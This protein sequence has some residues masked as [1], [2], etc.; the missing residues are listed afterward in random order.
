MSEGRTYRPVVLSKQNI[1]SGSGN[2]VAYDKRSLPIQNA[3]HRRPM[4]PM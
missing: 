1:F 4:R 3:M 2:G